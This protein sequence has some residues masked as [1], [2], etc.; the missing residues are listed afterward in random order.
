MLAVL[1]SQG[2]VLVIV[3]ITAVIVFVLSRKRKGKK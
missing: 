3:L 1:L 2:E